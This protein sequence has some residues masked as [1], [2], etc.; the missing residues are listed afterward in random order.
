M[1]KRPRKDSNARAA[2]PAVGSPAPGAYC[3]RSA[4]RCAIPVASRHTRHVTYTLSPHFPA[5][6]PARSLPLTRSLVPRVFP[7]RAIK[8]R[9][10]FRPEGLVTLTVLSQLKAEN[11]VRTSP[12][13]EIPACR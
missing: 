13:K 6:L 5:Y 9:R 12:P 3:D 10:R 4:R 11:T 2:E 7:R 8:L 1:K